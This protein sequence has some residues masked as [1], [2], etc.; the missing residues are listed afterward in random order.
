ME[1]K[2]KPLLSDWNKKQLELRGK[3]TQPLNFSLEAKV[4][5]VL[6]LKHPARV[7]RARYNVKRALD[8]L[9]VVW[10][11]PR[12]PELLKPCTM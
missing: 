8:D 10:R 12:S 6:E 2:K 1:Q 4:G 5:E 9:G 7:H 11:P 3:V